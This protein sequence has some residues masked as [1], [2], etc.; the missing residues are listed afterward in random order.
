MN[1]LIENVHAI[2]DSR[3]AWIPS[4]DSENRNLIGYTLW[5]GNSIRAYCAGQRDE[6]TA[7]AFYPDVDFGQNDFRC[8]QYKCKKVCAFNKFSSKDDAMAWAETFSRLVD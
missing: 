5:L 4:E 6:W 2:L 3:N 1:Y 8:Y 7:W